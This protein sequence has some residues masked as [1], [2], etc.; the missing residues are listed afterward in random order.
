MIPGPKSEKILKRI[1][2]LDIGFADFY[3]YVHSKKGSGCYF[4][5][6]DGN[7]FLDFAS[8]IASNPLGYNHPELK[9]VVSNYTNMTPIKY[10]GQDFA[11]TEHADLLE[12]LTSITP[13]QLNSAIVVNSGAEAVENCLKLALRKQEKGK[14]GIAFKNAFH[15]RTLGALSCTCSKPVQ[16]RNF[17]SIPVKHL[18]YDES[19]LEKLE[20]IIHKTNSPKEVGFV[21][22][23]PAQGEGGYNFAS[24]KLIKGLRK[25]TKQYNIPLI[26]DEVQS[27]V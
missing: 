3:P 8:H 5:D 17:L 18:P 20:K 26:C 16:K 21:I 13:R 6:I 4:T 7:E 14:F 19:A 9:K 1:R 25:I 12:S 11:I 10:A 24:T 27:G 2:R 15:G 23:E 22:I